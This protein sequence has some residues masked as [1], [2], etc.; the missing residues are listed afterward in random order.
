MSRTLFLFFVLSVFFTTTARAAPL[1]EGARSEGEVVLYSS[2]NNEQIVTLVDAFRKK[3]PNIKPSFYRG[4]SERVLQRAATEA[5]AGR[6][7]VDVVTSAGFQ[8]QL[9]K[10]SGLT[11]RFVPPE[12]AAY[13]E[14]FKDP[15]G[16]WVSVHSLLNSMAY[17]TQLV[18]PNEAP[19]RHEDLLAPRWKGRLGVNLQDPEWYVSL[20]RRWGIEKARNFLKA[21]AAQQ[22]G[23]RD[24]HNITAQ[25]LAAGEFQAVSNTYAHIVARIK[26]QGGPVQYVFDEPVITYVHP[27]TLMK[28]APHPNAGKLLISFILSLEGQRML[29]DQG[30]IPSHR[31]VDPLVFPLRNVKLFASDPKFAKDHAAAAEEMRGIFGVR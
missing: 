11:Q 8:V 13:R 7:A 30:R 15:D 25:L 20:Q 23:V 3:Y 16:H 5:K 6:F 21:L 22:P 28:T 9:L 14:G 18:K 27:I 26:G 17:N 29:R 12:A 2:L 24:G 31:D 4:T 10:D 1:E 19:K